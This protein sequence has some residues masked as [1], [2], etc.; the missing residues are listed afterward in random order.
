MKFFETNYYVKNINNEDDSKK[1]YF[2][3]YKLIIQAR[4][5]HYENYN[6]WMS[7][8][9]VMMAALFVAYFTIVD[10]NKNEF[11]IITHQIKIVDKSEFQF[12]IFGISILGCLISSLWYCANKGYYFWNINFITLVNYYEKYLLQYKEEERIY[13]V[14]ANKKNEKKLFLPHRGDNF[15][16]SKISIFIS[17]IFTFIWF[18]LLVLNFKKH[19]KFELNFF[20]TIIYYLFIPIGA[21]ILISLIYSWFLKSHNKHFPDLE[22]TTDKKD[23]SYKT[24]NKYKT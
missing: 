16:T 9:Y 4:N 6:K 15:S 21:I 10:K 3:R 18:A 23:N 5:F 13:Y 11:D 12:Y 1:E 14:F 22:I 8:F 20:C 24:I 19:F 7:Y 2:E 17:Y